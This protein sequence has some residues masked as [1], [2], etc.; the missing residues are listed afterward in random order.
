[1]TYLKNDWEDIPYLK[2]ESISLTRMRN[3][4][5]YTFLR[6][7]LDT[8]PMTEKEKQ[9]DGGCSA[10]FVSPAFRRRM[11]KKLEQL[12]RL[13]R[14]SNAHAETEL[15]KNIDRDRERAVL[16]IL[17]R[18][19]AARIST[20]DDERKAGEA[21]YAIT[22][23]YSGITRVSAVEKAGVIDSMLAEL[24]E[25]KFATYIQ[26]FKMGE[27]L[28]RLQFLNEQYEGMAEVRN[29]KKTELKESTKIYDLRFE[30]SV[31]YHEVTDRAFASNLITGNK[32]A[33]Y[34]VELLNTRI[35]D[36][37][38]KMAKRGKRV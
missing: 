20:S 29:K 26:Y 18:I 5:F 7:L 9:E 31:M 14:V 24:R 11:V 25:P 13:I 17:N 4:E 10:L 30:L 16:Y 19:D 32:E 2:V 28:G 37:K 15:L 6:R 38:E 22:K 21:L 35:K 23:N 33:E 8:M 12:K 34:Y 27:S 3:G 36:Y 1:M